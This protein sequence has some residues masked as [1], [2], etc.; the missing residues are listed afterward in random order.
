MHNVQ[1]L[2]QLM[3][4]MQDNCCLLFGRHWGLEYVGASC[5]TC[6]HAYSSSAPLL[7]HAPYMHAA[8]ACQAEHHTFF[9]QV[10]LLSVLQHK[11]NQLRV[12][13]HPPNVIQAD[14]LPRCNDPLKG[15]GPCAQLPSIIIRQQGRHWRGRGCWL[16]QVLHPWL[17]TVHSWLDVAWTH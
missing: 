2:L 6:L 1:V 11:S 10:G 14:N 16:W 9:L 17:S 4:M 8:P 3:M 12:Q 7:P 15:A 5:T 13:V